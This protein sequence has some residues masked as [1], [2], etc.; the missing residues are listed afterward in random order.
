[1]Q[2]AGPQ[3]NLDHGRGETK[4]A[5]IVNYTDQDGDRA[6]AIAQTADK[7]TAC[8]AK[9]A[10]LPVVQSS[11]FDLVLLFGLGSLLIRPGPSKIKLLARPSRELTTQSAK[12]RGEH[13][14]AVG[15][16]TVNLEPDGAITSCPGVGTPS[17]LWQPSRRSL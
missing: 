5:W 9:S 2:W 4:E 12:D 17:P 15:A 13:R 8:H 7:S 16:T 11:K 1:M 10:E 3:A 14:Q 6:V